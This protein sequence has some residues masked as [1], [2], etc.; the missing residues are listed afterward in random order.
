MYVDRGTN[1]QGSIAL[2]THD[3]ERQARNHTVILVRA[4]EPVEMKFQGTFKNA[5]VLVAGLLLAL[6]SLARTDGPSRLHASELQA[7]AALTAD[8][9]VRIQVEASGATYA[10]D[11]GSTRS[12]DDIGKV[13][14]KFIDERGTLRA[15][16]T[17]RTFSEF[18]TWV[19]VQQGAGGW[20]VANT[21]PL[22]FF[23]T[24]FSIP[25]P[26]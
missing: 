1:G 11:C 3:D 16:L 4:W 17:G 14:S 26:N 5:T 24:D 20:S 23:A 10:G 15:Y 7:N 6:A 25:W 18:N 12:P 13:C 9:A 22:D 2:S 21:E 8:D 19:F